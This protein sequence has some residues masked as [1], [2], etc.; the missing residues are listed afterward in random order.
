MK[1]IPFKRIKKYSLSLIYT[2]TP[3]TQDQLE[4]IRYK[5]LAQCISK[6]KMYQN[7]K[8]ENITQLKYSYC[9]IKLNN[10]QLVI[11]FIDSIKILDLTTGKYIKTLL[12]DDY[13]VSL[14]KL[15]PKLIIVRTFCGEVKIWNT[16]TGVYTNSLI[17][18][19]ARESMIRINNTQIAIINYNEEIKI[20]DFE[21]GTNIKTY[22]T[23]N[24]E[25]LVK[26]SNTQ[27]ASLHN[28]NDCT[29]FDFIQIWDLVSDKCIRINFNN[30]LI[31]AICFVKVG[32]NKIAIGCD[33]KIF[34]WDLQT[35]KHNSTLISHTADINCLAEL[36]TNKLASG[37]L[38]VTIKIWDLFSGNCLKTLYLDSYPPKYIAQINKT[39]QIVICNEQRIQIWNT[40]I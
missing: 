11:S 36:N 3:N 31:K 25:R 18:H 39:T 7:L 9:A 40:C 21:A 35:N 15:N 24:V 14:V 38:D 28:S 5:K 6:V 16:E 34:I 13:I 17:K 4:Q 12:T 10:N 30:S 19:G 2:I 1:C 33:S 29:K 27:I 32:Y 26:I 23:R 22:K 37:S 20:W 8:E